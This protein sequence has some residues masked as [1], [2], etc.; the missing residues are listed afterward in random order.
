MRFLTGN[1]KADE[2]EREIN[3][4]ISLIIETKKELSL[5]LLKDK[6]NKT[7]TNEIREILFESIKEY[8]NAVREMKKYFQDSDISRVEDGLDMAIKAD[9][10]LIYFQ[11]TVKRIKK[12]ET[13]NKGNIARNLFYNIYVQS[14]IQPPVPAGMMSCKNK[15]CE[16]NLNDLDK[17]AQNLNIIGLFEGTKE[18]ERK[19][20]AAL[21]EIKTFPEGSVI[22]KENDY[23]KEIY[24]INRGRISIRKSIKPGEP[25]EELVIL[26]KGSVTGEMSALDGSKRSATAIVIPGDAELYMIKGEDFIKILKTCPEV[27]INMNKIYAGRLRETSEKAMKYLEKTD[28]ALKMENQSETIPH[29]EREYQPENNPYCNGLKDIRLFNHQVKH[30][31]ISKETFPYKL[32]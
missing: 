21:I 9:K 11:N 22:F 25:E 1:M 8:K 14:Q 23:S 15:T 4:L 16:K 32:T 5:A 7:D 27:S 12:Q 18:T 30:K 31:F 29:R 13:E 2:L 28:R 3:S 24:I 17:I 6:Q 26:G 10:K 20:I 19:K